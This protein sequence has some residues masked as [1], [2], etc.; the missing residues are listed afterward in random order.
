MEKGKENGRMGLGALRCSP[1]TQIQQ[2]QQHH[3]YARGLWGMVSRAQLTIPVQSPSKWQRSRRDVRRGL[4]E[5]VRG[6]IQCPPDMDM[7]FHHLPP[8]LRRLA[9]KTLYRESKHFHSACP[10]VWKPETNPKFPISPQAVVE[11]LSFVGLDS[12]FWN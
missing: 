10:P 1:T 3:S 2:W 4:S 12:N 11:L 8:P 9:S 6:F 7:E 5:F